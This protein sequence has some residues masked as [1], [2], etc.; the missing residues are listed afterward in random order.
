MKEIAPVEGNWILP[1]SNPLLCPTSYQPGWWG[2]TVIAVSQSFFIT[3]GLYRLVFYTMDSITGYGLAII[4]YGL[5][6]YST[7]SLAMGWSS[8]L[9][10]TPSP[11]SASEWCKRDQHPGS[12]KNP[13]PVES[14]RGGVKATE[15]VKW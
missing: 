10:S 4:Y 6:H 2:I 8:P 9:S 15:H 13:H 7:L 11:P 12:T 1:S 3:I 5:Y 14:R